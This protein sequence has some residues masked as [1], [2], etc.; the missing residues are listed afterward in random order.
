MKDHSSS[1][2]L[3]AFLDSALPV[4]EGRRVENH[5]RDCP[6]CRE[7]LDDF[8][9][10]GALLRQW[11]DVAPSPDFESRVLNRIHAQKPRGAWFW[12]LWNFGA[13]LRWAPAA[14]A[15]ILV[16]GAAYWALPHFRNAQGINPADTIEIKNNIDLYLNY[17]VISH[18]HLLKQRENAPRDGQGET[19]IINTA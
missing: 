12:N 10:T 19:F 14:A 5:V 8:R 15:V 4:E 16:A 18:L 3:V 6:A 2:Q 17:D 11:T 13:P 7:T 1:E 9:R